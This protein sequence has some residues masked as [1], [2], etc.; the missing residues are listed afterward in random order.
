[1]RR[2]AGKRLGHPDALGEMPE[3][4]AVLRAADREL[5]PDALVAR[6]QRENP[7]VA[8]EVMVSIPPAILQRPSARDDPATE[9]VKSR[10]RRVSRPRQNSTSGP[11]APRRSR[12]ATSGPRRQA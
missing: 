4:P 6:E 2:A 1:M 12:R 7:W 11:N 10:R 5:Q 9:V 3:Q 8:A